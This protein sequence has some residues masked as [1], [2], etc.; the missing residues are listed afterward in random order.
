VRRPFHW[1]S[2][3]SLFILGAEKT[4]PQL[5]S[6]SDAVATGGLTTALGYDNVRRIYDTQGGVY[7]RAM[8][9]DDVRTTV[10][11]SGARFIDGEQII[12]NRR[13]TPS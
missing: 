4:G 7:N 13:I 5:P 11:D 9:V 1:S 10:Q 12:Q 3:F 6:D 8:D 2:L